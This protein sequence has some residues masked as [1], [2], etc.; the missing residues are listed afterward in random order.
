MPGEVGRRVFIGS[1][2]VA[3]VARPEECPYKPNDDW[4]E[5]VSVTFDIYDCDD[6]GHA[7]CIA[8]H[9]YVMIPK[10]DGM[11]MIVALPLT[12]EYT[13]KYTRLPGDPIS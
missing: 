6:L 13:L 4:G 12:L 8:R 3:L 1:L 10:R 11:S 5:I 9:P 2:L 7:H